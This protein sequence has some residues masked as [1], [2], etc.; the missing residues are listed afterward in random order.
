MGAG[1]WL[2]LVSSFVG[3][4]PKI[5]MTNSIFIV[6]YYIISI[7]APPRAIAIFLHGIFSLNI[8]I[9]NDKIK[10]IK[11]IKAIF[12]NNVYWINVKPIKSNIKFI[13][14][15]KFKNKNSLIKKLF[16]TIF[17]I[18]TDFPIKWKTAALVEYKDINL[19][20]KHTY[21]TNSDLMISSMENKPWISAITLTI[22]AVYGIYLALI[23]YNDKGLNNTTLL[24]LPIWLCSFIIIC[25]LPFSQYLNNPLFIKIT[26]NDEKRKKDFM[27]LEDEYDNE[28]TELINE[29]NEFVNKLPNLSI[30]ENPD[31]NYSIVEKLTTLFISILT[32]LVVVIMT[33]IFTITPIYKIQ[34]LAFFYQYKMLIY[35]WLFG[36]IFYIIDGII[37]LIITKY[38]KDKNFEDLLYVT[39]WLYLPS[40]LKHKDLINWAKYNKKYFIFR[41]ISMFVLLL[42]HFLISIITLSIIMYLFQIPFNI[43]GEINVYIISNKNCPITLMVNFNHTYIIS[44]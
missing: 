24:Q 20:W 9:K 6:I 25:G 13:K 12:S 1:E 22:Q 2:G 26:S 18:S 33:S 23:N 42:L 21:E 7:S 28:N 8:A 5:K 41:S 31:F 15:K 29:N 34:D 17:G 39:N 14:N 35:I 10:R 3:I 4:I 38:F 36:N 44:C 43:I 27:E 16:L 30:L 40:R 19:L 32:L 11:L 37:S